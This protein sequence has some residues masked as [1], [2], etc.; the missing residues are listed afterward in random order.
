MAEIGLYG[1]LGFLIAFLIGTLSEYVVHRLMHQRILLGKVHADHH[2]DGTGQGWL[3]EFKDYILPAFPFIVFAFGVGWLLLGSLPLGVGAAIGGLAYA[4]F[5]AYA[6][7]IQHEAP[8]LAFWMRRPVH[9]IH[10][11]NKM[12][13][14]NFG[15]SFDIWDRLCGTYKWVDWKPERPIRLRRFFQIKWV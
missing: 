6:H 2:A 7:Q 9:H 12:W 15:I 8:E 1:S 11:V 14:H 13:H 4:M 5:A 10:H 3:L